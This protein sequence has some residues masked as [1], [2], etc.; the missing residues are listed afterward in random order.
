MNSTINIQLTPLG[1]EKLPFWMGKLLIL[2]R[3]STPPL[4]FHRLSNHS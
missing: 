1:I 4:F 2:Q 3:E